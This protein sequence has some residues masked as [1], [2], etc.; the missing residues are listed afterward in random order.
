MAMIKTGFLGY[1]NRRIKLNKN[2]ICAITGATGSGKSWSALRLAQLLDKDFT[3]DNICFSAIDIMKLITG[4]TKEEGLKSGSV[5]VWDE[6][7]IDMSNVDWQSKIARVINQLLQTFRHRNFI[8]I[9]TM[10]YFDLMNKSS[11]KMYHCRMET[12]HI[13]S[14][15]GIVVIKPLLLQYNQRRGE[16]YEK[17]LRADNE[18][19]LKIYKRLNVGMPTAELIKVYEE[20]KQT[21]TDDLNK[22]IVKELEADKRK[23][24]WELEGQ[25]PK[26]T[27]RQLEIK[28]LLDQGFSLVEIG[29]KLNLAKQTIYTHK[30]RIKQLGR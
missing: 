8:F 15:K 1:V 2:F 19:K 28:P 4:E 26:Y 27:K 6:M 18:G 10:P 17:Y 30:E 12:L 13:D 24:K 20:K 9:A 14:K 22:N 16:T 23:S 25:K 5:I 7:Q 29:R 3:T 21:F 11:R